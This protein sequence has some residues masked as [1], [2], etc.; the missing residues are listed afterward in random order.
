MKIFI[1]EDEE[2]A[3]LRLKKLLS[4]IDNSIQIIGEAVSV[5]GAVKWLQNNPAPDLILMDIQLADGESFEIFGE[6]NV[7]SPVIFITAF[8]QHAVQA[9]KVNSVDYLLKPIKEEELS[10]ALEK[11]K[12]L[13]AEKKNISGDYGKL[14]EA[15]K[16]ERKEFQKRIIIRFG[17][18]I[19]TVEIEDVAYFYTQDKINFLRTKGGL[20]Y[21]M[22]MTLDETEKIL[23]STKFFRI[24][25]QFIVNISAIQKMLVVS[26]SRVKLTLN[27]PSQ[28]ETIVSTERSSHFKDWLEGKA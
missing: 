2:P 3:L 10:N 8:D 24:N 5:K 26:K 1:I 16:A 12:T 21:P 22:D 14:L 13:F 6:V 7:K 17:E 11:Y 25:R 4:K 15:L 18:T 9:F 19:K 20:D 27:P 28:I 23:D